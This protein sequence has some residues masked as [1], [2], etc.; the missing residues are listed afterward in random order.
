MVCVLLFF[1]FNTYQLKENQYQVIEKNFFESLYRRSI[2]H[3][4]IYPGGYAI[5]AKHIERNL[6]ALEG[7]YHMTGAAK[8]NK[9]ADSV[10]FSLFEE[11]R[12]KNPMDS[13]FVGEITDKNLDTHLQYLLCIHDIHLVL[14]NRRY[15]LYVPEVKFDFL[16]DTLQTKYGYIIGGKLRNPAP[17]SI[18][19]Y[20]T[21]TSEGPYHYEMA[22]AFYVD[23]NN[24]KTEIILLV[25]PAF[26]LSIISIASVVTVYYQTFLNWVRQKKLADM[27]SDFVNSITHEF[28][29]PLTTIMVANK[30]M[31]DNDVIT[32]PANLKTLINVIDRQS[33]HL[34]KLFNQVIDITLMDNG[35]IMDEYHDLG[36]LLSEAS[37]DYSV[38]LTGAKVKLNLI[39][40]SQSMMIKVNKFYFNTML[41]NLLDNAVKYN[42]KI[43]KQITIE[44]IK[45]LEG[46]SLKVKDNGMGIEEQDMAYIFDKFYRSGNL[47]S[48]RISG[49][50]LGLYYVYL[51][52]KSHGWQVSVSSELNVGTWFH[53]LIP[54]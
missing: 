35:P 17:K 20:M 48:N 54:Y 26:L 36:E 19:T 9:Y 32:N 39:I 44:A 53:I 27:K 25:L 40:P 50:G 51:C 30:S 42:D 15:P 34:K 31:L 3:D 5:M 23:K 14:N 47:V 21:I 28:N 6:K 22:F 11:L 45:T 10:L 1:T 49:L 16:P 52:I 8:H 18:I 41:N 37:H 2:L 43:E 24:R 46:Y 38:N 4:Q 13:L 29:T 7:S 33:S 12:A